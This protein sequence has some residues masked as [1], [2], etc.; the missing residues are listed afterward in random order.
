[1]G[2]YIATHITHPDTMPKSDGKPT[3][4]PMYGFPNGRKIRG[5]FEL[6][7]FLYRVLFC[8][9]INMYLRLSRRG[10]RI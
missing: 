7:L 3:F 9:Q 2:N 10:I 8:Y 6:N 1:M 5:M 4:D